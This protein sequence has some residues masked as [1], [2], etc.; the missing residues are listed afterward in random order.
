MHFALEYYQVDDGMDWEGT[1][2]CAAEGLFSDGMRAILGRL[3]G[4][5]NGCHVALFLSGS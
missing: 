1:L 5:M 2:G 3:N 4:E